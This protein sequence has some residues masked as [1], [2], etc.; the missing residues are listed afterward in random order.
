MSQYYELDDTFG[1]NGDGKAVIDLMTGSQEYAYSI[2]I[3][4][5]EKIVV[6]GYIANWMERFAII[7]LNVDG[8]LDTTFNTNG[9]RII[10]EA[11]FN[12]A[13]SVAID[14]VTNKI[15]VAGY[16]YASGLD[17]MVIRLNTDGT[18]DTSFNGTG[19]KT[20]NISGS[21]RAYSVLV[22]VNSKIF[23]AG[24]SGGGDDFVVVKLNTDGKFSAGSHKF[25][26]KRVL[27]EALNPFRWAFSA[28]YLK[29]L[30]NQVLGGK[31]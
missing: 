23:I 14:K 21:D 27:G 4:N 13:V 5:N 8:S 10:T 31:P 15:V 19:M 1:A 17:F 16:S 29:C 2:V 20:I 22:D 3:D 18:L 30:E 7:R 24:Y 6:A 26:E 25:I 11:Y 9:I 12:V 28:G